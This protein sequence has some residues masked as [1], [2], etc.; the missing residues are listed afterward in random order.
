MNGIE[1]K[2][3]RV[4]FFDPRHRFDPRNDLDISNEDLR[5]IGIS[6]EDE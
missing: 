3:D 5:L 4:S 1:P 2:G 6:D